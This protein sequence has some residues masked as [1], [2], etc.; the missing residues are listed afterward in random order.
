M[1]LYG[2][3][4]SPA[5]LLP[6]VGRMQQLA[7]VTELTE[8]A[9]PARGARRVL[10][11]CG[12]L[13]FDVHPDRGLDVSRLCYRGIP[14]TWESPA[15]TASPWTGGGGPLDWLRSFAGGLVT[16]CGLD[17]FGSPSED[18]GETF[19][20]HGRATTLQADEV[21]CSAGWRDEDRYELTVTGRLRQ[22]RLFGENLVLRRRISTLLGAPGLTLEDT[23]TNEGFERQ[24]H[25]QLYHV[26]LGWPLLDTDSV[27]H[28]PTR[29]VLPRDESAA[30]G[31]ALWNTFSQ[32]EAGFAEQVFRHVLDE[33]AEIEVRLA[34]PRL[35]LGLAL[36]FSTAE[37]P[38]LFQW[39]MLGAGTYVLGLE[40]AN[41]PVIE[42]RATARERGALPVLEPGES[43]TYRLRFD[44]IP[45]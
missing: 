7:S 26:N 5:H 6:R 21:A 42:G 20:L 45:V 31:T 30:A 36:S 8:D 43:R 12:E 41:C 18:A 1:N 24:P 35:S 40:P 9:G 19:P 33:D 23:V 2:Q 39:K 15:G 17:S 16:T 11:R 22:A 3:H 37:L 28:V 27:L 44:V 13:S 29:G 14:L 38:H 34:N 25:M 32:P 4:L 10:V